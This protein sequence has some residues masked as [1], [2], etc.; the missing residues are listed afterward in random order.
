VHS[1]PTTQHTTAFF[2][3]SWLLWR[4]IASMQLRNNRRSTTPG[5]QTARNKRRRS[6]RQHEEGYDAELPPQILF[7]LAQ[8]LQPCQ[9]DVASAS[10]VCKTWAKHIREGKER[11]LMTPFTNFN[12]N[13]CPPGRPGVHVVVPHCECQLQEGMHGV[14]AGKMCSTLPAALHITASA[15]V[16]ENAESA[17]EVTKQH[18]NVHLHLDLQ[19]RHSLFS[20]SST[21]TSQALSHVSPQSRPFPCWP[22]VSHTFA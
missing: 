3:L 7:M 16:L 20:L 18:C 13:E 21:A 9:E 14:L 4:P 17:A 8:Q 19:P 22:P 12:V 6:S 5:H 11:A 10:A 2:G 15:A 1:T